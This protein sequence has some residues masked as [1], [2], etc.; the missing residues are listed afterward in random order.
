MDLDKKFVEQHPSVEFGVV[1]DPIV[2]SEAIKRAQ[3]MQTAFMDPGYLPMGL[4]VYCTK[5]RN[6]QTWISPAML[7]KIDGEYGL[8]NNTD[9]GDCGRLYLREGRVF[10]VHIGT[11]GSNNYNVLVAGAEVY[12]WIKTLNC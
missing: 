4:T 11:Y 7:C 1:K 8:K 9:V 2:V 12:E 3:G 5:V 6:N 10:G